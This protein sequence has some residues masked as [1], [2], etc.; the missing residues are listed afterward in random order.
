MYIRLVKKVLEIISLLQLILNQNSYQNSNFMKT[1][2]IFKYFALFL[3]LT[4][5][6]CGSDDSDSGSGG[7]QS[8]SSITA[9]M[10]I[11][12]QNN[13]GDNIN[14]VVG[15]SVDFTAVTNTGNNVSSNVVVT[16]DGVEV[17]TP[18]SF[19]SVGTFDVV[20]TYTAADGS[21][22][23]DTFTV[24][25]AEP[26]AITLSGE[27]TPSTDNSVTFIVMDDLGN[28]VTNNSTFTLN[29]NTITNPHVFDT[30]GTYTV[31]AT[32]VTTTNNTLTSNTLSLEITNTHSTKVMV[33]DYTG[34]WCGY[35]P[36][37]AYKIDQ[38]S[39]N[40]SKV[41]PV[42]IHNG[43]SMA[44]SFGST[45]ENA[46]GISGFPTGKINR[47]ITWNETDSQ[48]LNEL[49]NQKN[50]GLAIDSNISGSTLTVTAKVHFSGNI[51][52][53]TKLVVYVLEDGII[54]SQANYMNNDSSSPWYQAG[55]PMP[56]FEH[57]N[58][59]RAAL[60][61]VLGDDV[62]APSFIGNSFSKDFTYSIPASYDTANLEIVAFVVDATGKTINVQYVKAGQNQAFD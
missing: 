54:A 50:V 28:N 55:N 53:S 10:V 2:S 3:A 39:Q 26:T 32:Y 59:A 18:Y 35:C 58:V 24:V 13:Y 30:N 62:T 38:L 42:A 57:N 11:D 33:E 16:V 41:I 51:T 14:L 20:V 45:L 17:T 56:N 37:L 31:E 47:T 9:A 27:A 1:N 21:T 60:T 49:N 29:G 7:G 25:V 19:D 8:T 23:T 12:G 22:Y 52:G 43:D 34:T 6:S 36:R 48:V 15:Q 46:A 40:N 5:M 44:P 61:N 4:I